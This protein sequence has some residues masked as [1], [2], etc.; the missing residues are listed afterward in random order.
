M[1]PARNFFALAAALLMPVVIGRAVITEIVLADPEVLIKQV[2]ASDGTA[3]TIDDLDRLI[4]QTIYAKEVGDYQKAIVMVE[5][6][7]LIQEMVLGAEHLSTATS[8]N[9]LAFLYMNQGLYNKAEP[10]LKRTLAITEKILGAG[11][12][13]TAIRLNN[14]AGLY[15]VQGLYD[16]AEPLYLRSLAKIGR[17][18]V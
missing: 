3:L 16:K 11:H 1:N 5:K 2:T 14:L 18:H 12:P 9:N 13:T 8:L 17:A 7:L 6:I 4:K 10:I 15:S